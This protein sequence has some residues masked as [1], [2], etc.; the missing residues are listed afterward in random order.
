M[1]FMETI[2]NSLGKV[3]EKNMMP[4]QPGDVESTY[5]D[6]TE[7]TE[8]F[9]YKPDTPLKKGVSEFTKWYKEFYNI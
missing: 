7:L 8:N 1:E 6:T 2:E 5:A 3:A 4:I 9:D